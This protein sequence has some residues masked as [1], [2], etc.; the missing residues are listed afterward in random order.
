VIIVIKLTIRED[1]GG[2]MTIDE[3]LNSVK[4]IYAKHFPDSACRA[5]LS[6]GL[7]RAIFIDFYL[8]KDASEVYNGIWQNDILKCGLVIHLEG[9]PELND[10][11]PTAT[12]QSMGSEMLIAPQDRYVAYSAVRIPFR[13]TT[14]DAKKLL[15]VI[16][17]YVKRIADTLHE[18]VDR[19]VIANSHADIVNRK[20]DNIR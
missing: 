16:E 10:A 6:K 4:E 18:A 5:V 7:G 14:G 15:T 13:K 1:V 19:G 20:I 9:Y 2:A 8:A 12:L 11:M 17:K 3:F